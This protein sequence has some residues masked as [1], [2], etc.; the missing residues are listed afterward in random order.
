MEDMSQQISENDAR[1]MVRLLGEAAALGGD[2]HTK[3]KR[4][5]MDGLCELISADAWAWTLGVSIKPGAQQTYAGI[6]HGGF[7]EQRFADLLIAIEHP[8]MAQVVAPF[9][10]SL[11]NGTPNTMTRDEIDP[12]GLAY[13]E[14][15]RQHW[16]TADIGSLM[17]SGHPLDSCSLSTLGVYRGY[18]GK[19]FSDREKQI[20]HIILTEV[21]WLHALGWP[22]DRGVKVPSLF[23]KQRITLNLLLEGLDRKTIAKRMGIAENTVAGY[24]KDVYRHFGVN[25]QPQLMSKFLTGVPPQS[26][27]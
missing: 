25:S 12:Q 24:A 18:G 11:A 6:L 26:G 21:P 15:V 16:E 10:Q 19:P 22:E 20:A 5:L 2:D 3:T 23:P 9:F 8:A 13:A 27:E 7:D 14:G 17:M 1:A 4:F